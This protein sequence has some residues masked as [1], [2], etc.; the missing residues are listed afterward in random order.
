MDLV[1]SKEYIIDLVELERLKEEGKIP[2]F[3]KG[4]FK[5]K[6]LVREKSI[7]DDPLYLQSRHNL[8]PKCNKYSL[9]FEFVGLFD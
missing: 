6:R 7:S 5:K 4:M 2:Y 9:S 1:N 8:C 3:V